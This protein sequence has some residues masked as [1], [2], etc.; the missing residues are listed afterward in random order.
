MK[1]KILFKIFQKVHVFIFKYDVWLSWRGCWCQAGWSTLCG[2][3]E[4]KKPCW[5]QRRKARLLALSTPESIRS[6]LGSLYY[7]CKLLST[8]SLNALE[9]SPVMFYLLQKKKNAFVKSWLTKTHPSPHPSV[10]LRQVLY[11]M[12]PECERP[13]SL[14]KTHNWD[15]W[16]LLSVLG[17]DQWVYPFWKKQ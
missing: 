12:S 13:R 6:R 2:K 4:K 17:S 9:G 8:Q 16:A 5:C 3:K 1:Q 15:L 11:T 14:G 10:F 7:D